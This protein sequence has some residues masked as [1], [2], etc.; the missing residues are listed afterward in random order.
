MERCIVCLRPIYRSKNKRANKQRRMAIA[1][2]CNKECSRVYR[3]IIHYY[4]GLPK[5]RKIEEIQN[6]IE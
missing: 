5:L 4:R 2:T 1:V 6:G 3:R